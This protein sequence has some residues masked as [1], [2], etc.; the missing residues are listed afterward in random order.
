MAGFLDKFRKNVI[1]SVWKDK[2]DEPEVKYIDDKI[3]L[4]VCYGLSQRL[5]RNF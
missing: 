1:T 5:M 2:N 4:G 3:A